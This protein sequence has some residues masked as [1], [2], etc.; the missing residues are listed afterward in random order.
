MLLN[1][2]PDTCTGCKLSTNKDCGKFIKPTGTGRNKILLVGEASGEHEAREGRPFIEYAP[3]GSIL[4]K[5]IRLANYKR[6]DFIIFNLIACR[7]PNNILEGASYESEAIAHCRSNLD[8]VIEEFKP[9]VIVALGA[10]PTKYLTGFYSSKSRDKKSISYSRGFILNSIYDIP[11]IPTYHP[12][13]IVRGNTRLIPL[14]IKDLTTAKLVASDKAHPIADISS[15]ITAKE[16]LEALTDFYNEVKANPDIWIAYDIETAQS[17][18]GEEDELVEGYGGS[19]EN[20][21]FTGEIQESK[22]SIEI[23]GT[24]DSGEQPNETCNE[25]RSINDNSLDSREGDILS[26]QFAISDRWG[27]YGDWRDKRIRELSQTILNLPNPKVAHNGEKFDLPIDRK[28][29]V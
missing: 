26:I 8:K 16:G 29:V 21:V 20:D 14:L 22:S 17:I 28:S 7:P 10:L 11:C 1:G 18:K 3:A 19:G 4:E 23:D 9:K 13:Y 27:V 24:L 25:I 15:E 12:A 6:N 2:L 5:A